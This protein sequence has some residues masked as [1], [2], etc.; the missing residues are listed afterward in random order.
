V[1]QELSDEATLF[2]SYNRGFKSGGFNPSAK[3]SYQPE[4]L[5]AYEAGIKAELFDRSLRVNMAGFYYDYSNM[6]VTSFPRAVLLVTNGG[7]SE[8][9]GVDIDF[10]AAVSPE[11]TL[12][13]GLEVLHAK[14]TKFDDAPETLPLPTGGN[15][16]TGSVYDAA[17]Q[18]LP[19]APQ[20]TFNIGANYEKQIDSGK[21]VA[22][23]LWSYNDGWFAD[24]DNRVRQPNYTVLNA[25]VGFDMDNGIGIRLWGKN[26]TDEL[27]ATTLGVQTLADHVQ[28]A[29]PRTYGAT[30]SYK[31]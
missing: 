13:G 9:Y 31:F 1:T 4:V 17:G 30:V 8:I 22:N 11:F 28:Y 24:A 7:K 20:L 12:S 10:Q 26:L 2:A 25:S 6:Q 21:I 15:A 14:F 3:N 29:A 19:K 5:D 27:Y 23:I 16:Q 18:T